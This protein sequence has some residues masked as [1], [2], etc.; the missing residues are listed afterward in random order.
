M[1]VPNVTIEYSSCDAPLQL[2][3][4]TWPS[5]Y[6][7][8]AKTSDY[9]QTVNCVISGIPTQAETTMLVKY[10]SPFWQWTGSGAGGLNM[11]CLNSEPDQPIPSGAQTV[12]PDPSCPAFKLNTILLTQFVKLKDWTN[13]FLL[14]TGGP[15][16]TFVSRKCTDPYI[17]LTFWRYA[18][19]ADLNNEAK[20]TA[21]TDC[22]L[23]GSQLADC[24]NSLTDSGMV[25][26]PKCFNQTCTDGGPPPPA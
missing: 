2:Q 21:T 13:D 14:Y 19:Q 18:T 7:T 8:W 23:T 24:T 22:V 4:W 17:H 11:T 12:G 6:D 1:D 16:S 10:I 20:P 3:L 5:V 15:T 25:F 9:R 26:D